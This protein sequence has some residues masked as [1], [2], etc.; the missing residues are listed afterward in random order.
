MLWY[1]RILLKHEVN[2]RYYTHTCDEEVTAGLTF[3]FLS[4]L[5][6]SLSV[7]CKGCL[8]IHELAY[9]LVNPLLFIVFLPIKNTIKN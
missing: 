4:L 9:R 8:V 3:H 6:L 7:A 2:A 5:L 1:F